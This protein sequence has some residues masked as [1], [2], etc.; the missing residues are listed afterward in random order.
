MLAEP[1][2]ERNQMRQSVRGRRAGCLGSRAGSSGVEGRAGGPAGERHLDAARRLSFS[3]FADPKN[4]NPSLDSASPTL[5]LAMFIYSW[6]IRYD[7][8][9]RPFP[10]A[11][12]EV[13]T[14]ANGDVSKDGLTLKYKLRQ[15]IKWQ[16]GVP[17]TCKI[18]SSP[19]KW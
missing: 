1:G 8:K 15:N 13:P 12:V 9:A 11:L 14:L 4:L 3:E 2:E 10:D 5:D 16:D 6:T 7:S 18:S 17:L 19:G